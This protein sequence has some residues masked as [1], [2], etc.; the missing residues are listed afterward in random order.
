MV[1]IYALKNAISPTLTVIG[2]TFAFALTGTF[3]VEIIFNWPGLGSLYCALPAQS[4]L[5]CHHGYYALWCRGICTHQSRCG[6]AAG[7]DRPAHQLEMT[8][9]A[10]P[11]L[12]LEPGTFQHAHFKH[13]LAVILRDPLS[14]ISTILIIL[15]I[16]MAIFAYQIAPYPRKVRVNPMCLIPCCLLPRN[17]GLVPIGWG[18]MCSAGSSW[19]RARH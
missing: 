16:L 10:V 1:Y 3:F 18:G 2:L 17:I 19:A 7:V 4:R 15:F 14:L 12:A 6:F 5:S 8:M 9:M 13:V 11:V